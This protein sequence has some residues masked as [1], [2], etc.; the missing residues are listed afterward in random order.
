MTC[1]LNYP[2]D[3]LQFGVAGLVRDCGE[4]GLLVCGD[5][6]HVLKHNGWESINEDFN[7]QI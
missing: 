6:C 3:A 2:N 1:E 5:G 4:E 7:R